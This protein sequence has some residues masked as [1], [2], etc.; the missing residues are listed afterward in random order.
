M[1]LK[2]YMLHLDRTGESGGEIV[3]MAKDGITGI[4]MLYGFVDNTQYWM[5]QVAKRISD[6]AMLHIIR[7]FLDAGIMEDNEIHS[8]DK[9]TLQVA[10]FHT[11]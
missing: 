7:Q 10:L 11:A 6:G 1:E 2:E 8:Q 3:F 9:G 4:I 5:E